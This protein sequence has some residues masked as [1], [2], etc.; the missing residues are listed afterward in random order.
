MKVSKT[1]ASLGSGITKEEKF[2]S[3]SILPMLKSAT[4]RVGFDGTSNSLN[5]EALQY[6]RELQ[7][8]VRGGVVDTH[9]G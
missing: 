7:Y 9:A 3:S 1:G 6:M 8:L 2:D 4:L 5:E